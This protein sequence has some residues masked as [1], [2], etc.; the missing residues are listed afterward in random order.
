ML[1]FAE[2]YGN[3]I[4]VASL[5]LLSLFFITKFIPLR[6]K[7]EKRSGGAL[8]AFIIALFA[9]MYGFPLTIYI[10][11]S[12][13]GL[14]IPLT[15]QYGHLWAYFLTYLGISIT[16]GWFIVM[17]LSTIIMT[18]GLVLII[19]SWKRIYYSRGRMITTGLY[20]KMRHP[21]YSGILLVTFAFLI[22]WPT[23]ITL[24]MWP[25]LFLMYYRLAQREE[26]NVQKKYKKAFA[27]YKKEVPM[28]IPSLRRNIS[29]GN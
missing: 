29:Y 1:L 7:F 20:S 4:F 25:F 26:R 13:L 22:Q 15:H 21:Q 10:L 5:I 16:Y 12:F 2:A 24:I 14:K 28:F 6:T 27:K 9:E 23:I 8:I 3:W 11:S 18:I 17:A 19:D